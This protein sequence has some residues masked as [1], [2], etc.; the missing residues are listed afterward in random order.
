MCRERE[1]DVIVKKYKSERKSSFREAQ[2]L[3]GL[4]G[5]LINSSRILH[6]RSEWNERYN[7]E[8]APEGQTT[9]FTMSPEAQWVKGLR[10]QN[11]REFSSFHTEGKTGLGNNTNNF[12]TISSVLNVMPFK[13]HISMNS[14]RVFLL[15]VANLPILQ[16]TVKSHLLCETFSDHNNLFYLWQVESKVAFIW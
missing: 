14:F 5:D 11:I 7:K 9:A 10:G 4:W 16:S 8:V 3:R 15:S 12:L 13:A 6:L 2:M 1:V